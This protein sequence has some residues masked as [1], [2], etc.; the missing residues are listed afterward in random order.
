MSE[1]I[2][3]VAIHGRTAE[4]N[5]VSRPFRC[6][7]D[8]GRDYFVKLKNAGYQ[9]LV[10]EWVAGRL[11][12]EMGLPVAEVS[13]VRISPDLI[14][15][16]QEYETEM[17]HGIAFGSVKVE[18]AERLSLEF[19]RHDDSGVLSRILLFD[20]WVRNAD[21]ALTE[22][23]GNPNLL[24]EI[25]PGRV[26]MIDHDNAFD[27]SFDVAA[28]RQFHALRTHLGSW[29]PVSRAELSVWLEAGLGRLDGIWSEIPED[30]LVDSYGDSQCGLDKEGLKAVLL[31]F[32]K[33][34]D[35]WT[36]PNTPP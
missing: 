5:G 23:G 22:I 26:V 1:I 18:A 20:W 13:Q 28:F 33:D 34:P 30:W 36:I 27:S 6:E 4:G 19:I 7:G 2:D 9:C 15:G 11:A 3:I 12:Q 25:H 10:K 24:W 8:D 31:S 16:N 35:F 17:G 14:A 32:R 29:D 21:R